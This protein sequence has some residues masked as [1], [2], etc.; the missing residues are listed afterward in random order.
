MR[1]SL[2]AAVVAASVI[3]GSSLVLLAATQRYAFVGAGS[4]AVKLDRLTGETVVCVVQPG[5][6]E[7]GHRTMIAPCNGSMP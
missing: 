7:S 1:L 3:V 2:P 5:S 4:D 6:R